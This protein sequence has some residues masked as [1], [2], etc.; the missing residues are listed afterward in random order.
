MEQNKY[1][2]YTGLTDAEV[3][4]SRK[5]HGTNVL[6]PPVKETFWDKVKGCCKNPFIIMLAILLSLSTLGFAFFGNLLPNGI[7]TGTAVLI[8]L[9][10]FGLLVT[11]FG[12]LED[13]LIKI[14]YVALIL[15][16]GIAFTQTVF[17]DKSIAFGPYLEPIGIAFAILIATG[18]A[19]FLQKS[20]EKT[21]Q[22][23]NHVND[24]TLVKVIRNDNICQVQRKDIVVGDVVLLETGEEIPAD[25]ELLESFNLMVDESSLTGEP[26]CE[27]NANRE[28]ISKDATY[29]MYKI[30][31][32]CLVV[33][34][35][36]TAQVTKVGDETDCGKVFEAAQVKEGNPTPL[37]EKLNGLAKLITKASYIIAGLILVG[38]MLV[39]F[40]QGNARFSCSADW[41]AFIKY[42]LDTVMIAV[43]IIVV[44]VPEGLPMAV[45]LSLAFSMKRLMEQ[46]TL[47]RTMHACETMG[48]ASV[49]CTDK[50]GTLTQN[51]MK[52]NDFDF[53]DLT[54][55]KLDD[56]DFSKLLIECI[57]VD[58]TANLD[59]AN[60][61]K[62][63]TIGSPTEGAV[64]LWLHQNG[65]NYLPVRERFSVIDRL[66][67]STDLKYMATI[68]KSEVFN[69]KVLYVIGAPEII[70]AYSSMTDSEKNYYN[71]KLLDYQNKAMRTLGFAYLPLENE[72][73]VFFDGHLNI[74]DLKMFGVVAIADPIRPEVPAAI[75]ECLDAGIQVKIVT[76]DAPGTA[77]EIGR[78]LG[79][80]SDSDTDNN[81]MLGKEV[82]KKSDDELKLILPNVK[83]ISRARPNDKE[84]VVRILK[85]LNMVVAVTG[86][87]TND[88]P[89]LNAADVGL[90]MGDGTA[91]AKEASDMTILDN[92][93][94]TIANAVMW[95]RSLYKNI[96]RFILFQMT[97]NVAAC[98]IVFIGAFL[99]TDTPLTVT[100]MLWVNLI[101]DA[102]AA[103]ALASLPPSH[104]VMA[105]KP[106][107]VND[108]ILKGMGKDILGVGGL[109]SVILLAV[110][111]FLQHNNISSLSSLS[112][113]WGPYDGLSTYELGLFFTFFVMLHFWYMFNSKVYMTNDSA[114]KGVRKTKYFSAIV[115]IVFIGQVAIV[116]LPGLQ[117]MF[118]VAPGGLNFSDWAIIVS[119]TS[120]V[121][122]IGELKR[123]L[124]RLV[125][126]C[127]D[128][129]Y[130]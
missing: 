52:V 48:A 105:E 37:T 29:P 35:Y 49:I 127:S 27:K 95:G 70:M 83:I 114:F 123:L 69:K 116:E 9:L 67:V 86:D 126:K 75:K 61:D 117:E 82:N 79:L 2:H 113:T 5:K 31:K 25:C 43:T 24:E 40:I 72:D 101:M 108:H 129:S 60:P 85:D 21:F 36:C 107:S 104:K 55:G 110:L 11:F 125:S 30:L 57:A 32:G 16:G 84:R 96:K 100:Q 28:V 109:F 51:Q 112:F 41:V 44:A 22:S 4:E 91:V 66:P 92:S 34:G 121:M 39:F 81:I 87:G 20:N 19:F 45:T 68:V 118:N 120:L 3:L 33:Q 8:F 97:V 14:L 17:L 18:V 77:K 13:P 115:L 119:S 93:F 64:L 54:S 71:A 1:H 80:W 130:N 26:P 73:V 15:S 102:F 59:Y 124:L 74:S 76:G 47:P 6:T 56:S 90:S 63:K 128:K 23:L 111:L 103:I 10:V 78:Q 38:R 7:W 65:I 46:N 53:P 89:A 62:I 58:T 98:F 99:G 122:W 88:A 42:V 12:G 50:T 106:R 94:N